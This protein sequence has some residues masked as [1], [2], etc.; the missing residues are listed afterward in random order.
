MTGIADFSR[1][2]LR[3]ST[4]LLGFVAAALLTLSAFVGDRAEASSLLN[5]GAAAAGKV[6]ADGLAI[7]VRGVGGG[8]SGRGGGGGGYGGRGGY[9]GHAGFGGSP[10]YQGGASRTGPNVAGRTRFGGHHFAHGR[11]FRRV[12]VG[13]VWYDYPYD[14][15]Y[16]YYEGYPAYS[17]APG[18][19]IVET[20]N[21]PQQLCSHRPWRHHHYTRRHHQRRH[22]QAHR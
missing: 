13:G 18:C 15:D 9:G 19:R 22:H 21:G 17:A 20:E 12:F 3:T 1:Y 10:S 7:E 4:R 5:P 8:G 14:D 6:A 16:P 2:S 11:H